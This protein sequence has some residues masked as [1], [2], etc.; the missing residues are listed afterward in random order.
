LI[1]T[2]ST[3]VVYTIQIQFI[4]HKMSSTGARDEKEKDQSSTSSANIAIYKS[5]MNLLKHLKRQGFDTSN[6]E[7]TGTHEV[8]TMQENDQ[9]DMLLTTSDKEAPRRTYVKYFTTPQRVT[10]REI[11]NVVDD[12]FTL[13]EVLSPNGN[14]TLI[15]VTKHAANDT[16]MKL[17][18]QLWSQSC[19]FIIIFTLDQLQ[20]NILEHQY[21]PLHEIL[22]K[23][24]TAEIIKRFNVTDTDQLPNIS[25]YDPVAQAIGIRPGEICRITRP[26]KTS[27]TSEYY[28][29]CT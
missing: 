26:S 4:F 5:R 11:H 25:R 20:F 17:L 21:V 2:I 3:N 29:I 12:L 18:N 22:S 14:D 15:L 13:D 23:S 16:A 9:L 27:I 1:K 28:R 6:Y 8:H 24:Q 7:G 19:Y 10:P